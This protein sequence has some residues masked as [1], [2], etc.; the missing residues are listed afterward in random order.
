MALLLLE[1]DVRRLFTMSDALP[2]VEQA[3]RSLARGEAANFPRQRG[4]LPG[5]T[6][7]VL[8]A[9]SRTLDAA[10]VKAYPIIR[11]DVTVGSTL[12]LLIYKLSTGAVDAILEASLLGQIRTG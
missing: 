10:C 8:S 11:S 7:N 6:L 12:T 2:V 9:M 4:A 5:A 1:A 3:F